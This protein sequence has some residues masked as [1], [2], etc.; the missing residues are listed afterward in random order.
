VVFV[1]ATLR[2]EMR[3]DRQVDGG[4]G[5]AAVFAAVAARLKRVRVHGWPRF[6]FQHCCEVICIIRA[7]RAKAF[8]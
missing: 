2:D 3:A 1:T 4:R 7:M 5:V 8:I 6:D